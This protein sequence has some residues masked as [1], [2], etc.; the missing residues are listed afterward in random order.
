MLSDPAEII[1]DNWSSIVQR[2]IPEAT[3]VD[4]SAATKGVVSKGVLT[5]A[6]Q[7]KRKKITLPGLEIRIRPGSPLASDLPWTNG[8]QLSS[9]ARTLVDNL[10]VSRGRTGRVPTTLSMAEIE[11]WLA[12]KA[13]A[14]G[15]ARTNRLKT[16][17]SDLARELRLGDR[18]ELVQQLF[19][20]LAGFEP[21]RKQSG[22]LLRAFREGK[23]W[24]E[25]RLELFATAASGLA[26]M[27]ATD[28]P[29]WLPAAVPPGELPFYE[30]YFSNYIEG[31]EFTIDEART[32]VETQV[33]PVDRPGDGHDILGTYR[34]V[35]DPVA[36][37]ATSEDV[38]DLLSYLVDRHRSILSGRPETRPGEWKE[39]QNQ[40]GAYQ[41]VAPELVEGTLTKGLEAGRQLPPGLPR[42]LYV[43][44]V[45]S[46]VHPFADGNGR[47]ARVMMNAEL[48][49]MNLS[50]LVIPNVYRNEYISSLRR[51]STTDGDVAGFIKVMAH[52]WRWTSA[53]P[54]SDRSATE[55]HLQATNALLDSAD[56]Q[57][58][59]ARLEIP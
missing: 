21:P 15:E 45:I 50:R 54:W 27:S 44:L 42:A 26:T 40:V 57:Q 29:E 35:V 8:L 31:T 7:S 11:D 38:D 33:P 10:A 25:R 28:V 16:G 46:E 59:G 34:C 39:K 5:L 51:V 4:R 49:A 37:S 36:R 58:S 55:G 18:A 6:G 17:A 32:I 14:Y 41:F 2:L 53:M 52:A 48:S 1:L 3:I 23:A 22:P 12:G 24:D 30:A 13:I 9:P 47:V 20:R 43:M 56:A 19:D